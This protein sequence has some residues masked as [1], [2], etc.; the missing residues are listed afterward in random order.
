MGKTQDGEDIR[1][2]QTS[3]YKCGDSITQGEYRVVVMIAE[4]EPGDGLSRTAG[5]GIS[6]VYNYCDTCVAEITQFELPNPYRMISDL[7]AE[8]SAGPASEDVAWRTQSLQGMATQLSEREQGGEADDVRSAQEI[9][10]ALN[11]TL[12]G[13]T[14]VP[15]PP[16]EDDLRERMRLFRQT[17]DGRKMPKQLRIIA[18]KWSSG[19]TQSQIAEAM[20]VNQ[21]TVSRRLDDAKTWLYRP[22]R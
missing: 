9:E 7:L 20:G 22:S 2:G 15:E 11:S 5:R 8:P 1:F 10:A 13:E 14:P 12:T 18:D 19:E 17:P 21:S 4:M 3:C 16:S 6:S